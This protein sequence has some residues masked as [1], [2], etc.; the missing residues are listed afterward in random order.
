MMRRLVF[1][2][3][4]LVRLSSDR[5]L[6]HMRTVALTLFLCVHPLPS[7]GSFVGP[8][9]LLRQKS[10]NFNLRHHEQRLETIEPTNGDH[11]AVK[12]T[13][14]SPPSPGSSRDG[15]DEGTSDTDPD[16][17]F[18]SLR[19]KVPKKL[20]YFMRDS[21][22][23]RFL[24]DA[25][26]PLA[27]PS[28]AEHYPTAMYDFL[29][30]S[31]RIEV[32]ENLANL[33]IIAPGESKNA[34]S[35]ERILYGSH[36]RQLVDVMKRN[37][38]NDSKSNCPLVVFVH[39]G[40]CG[41]GFPTMYRSIATPFVD[42]NM[43]VGVVGYRTYPDAGVSGHLSD[44]TEALKLLKGQFH[45]SKIFLIGHST[46][47]NL[48]SMALLNEIATGAASS[49][50]DS[51]RGIVGLAGLYDIPKH[52]LFEK[53]RG[54]ERISPIAPAFGGSYK[55][56]KRLSPTRKLLPLMRKRTRDAADTACSPRLL[57]C[58]G[59]EDT[60]VPFS[61]SVA[62]AKAWKGTEND[63]AVQ[64]DLTLLEGVG[65]ADCVTDLMFGGPTRD[66]VLKWIQ[67]QNQ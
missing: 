19:R 36:P 24:M 67:Q 6:N 10:P 22:I 50:F 57:I 8:P 32:A 51:V 11:A 64:C 45:D 13:P 38:K 43:S 31:S 41:S 39:G 12:T 55:D 25:P 48:V 56:W 66:V 28:I 47:A 54:I 7:S 23:I 46:G 9:D 37:I 30:L 42:A 1:L 35:W 16:A 59:L 5:M 52:Y 21:G 53:G 44:L 17:F 27:V 61:S 26:V 49:S 60:V 15:G 18:R 34:V 3:S 62:Y 29:R 65:H 14:P 4:S 20:Q 2:L 33:S 63:N 58:H 40:A